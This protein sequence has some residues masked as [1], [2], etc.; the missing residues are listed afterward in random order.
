MQFHSKHYSVHGVKVGSVLI[1][2]L[3]LT[4]RKAQK[5][6]R[7]PTS[8]NS[9]SSRHSKV[10]VSWVLITLNFRLNVNHENKKNVEMLQHFPVLAFSVSSCH[11][12][13][14][15]LNIARYIPAEVVVVLYIWHWPREPSICFF[16]M[17]WRNHVLFDSD[18]GIFNYV[19][20]L[21]KNPEKNRI[22]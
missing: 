3:S 22:S 15:V 17:K 9:F 11:L 21:K 6:H 16:A 14:D 1:F 4:Q 19:R 8:P 20:H 2:F 13:V 5:L 12:E 18:W 7:I 10:S